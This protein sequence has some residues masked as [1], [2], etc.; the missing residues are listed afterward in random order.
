MS[1]ASELTPEERRKFDAWK[2][3]NTRPSI[4]YADLLA[5]FGFYYGW[6]AI[7]DVLNDDVSASL[8]FDLLEAGR[9]FHQRTLTQ[10]MVDECNANGAI[11]SKK[12]MRQFQRMVK[13]R[14]R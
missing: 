3:K 2:R 1:W 6:D 12:A 9:R 14:N 4:S 7:R 13:E 11:Q 10:M 5:E 8:F